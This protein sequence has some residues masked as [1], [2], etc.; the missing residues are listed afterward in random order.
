MFHQQRHGSDSHR[1]DH[2]GS[3][4]QGQSAVLLAGEVSA[5]DG[6][7]DTGE[8]KSVGGAQNLAARVDVGLGPPVVQV[9]GHID[10]QPTKHSDQA[11]EALKSGEQVSVEFEL[12]EI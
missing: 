9:E 1:P 10:V 5:T 11:R 8:C 3:S 2:R 4:Y 12:G 6:L 7:A